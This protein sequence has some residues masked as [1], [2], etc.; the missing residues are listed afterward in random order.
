MIRRLGPVAAL[1]IL[2]AGL[3]GAFAANEKDFYELW[4]KHESD[5][6]RH[7]E[8]IAQC[9]KFSEFNSA[10]PLRDVAKSLEAW[11]LLV[12]GRSNEAWEIFE[13]QAALA[14]DGVRTGTARVAKG[15][16][17]RRER[18]KVAAS[19]KLFYREEIGFPKS[20]AEISN[21]PKIPAEARPPVNDRF[22]APW[23][24]RLSGFEKMPG[25]ENQKYSLECAELGPLSDLR[26]SLELPYAG[27]LK[28]KPVAVNPGPAGSIVSFQGSDSKAM[29]VIGE[30]EAA[31]GIQLAFAGPGL[32]MVCDGTHWK[33]F[34][35]PK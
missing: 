18:E 5:P 24:Y 1:L 29:T 8:I 34:L 26:K 4:K 20:L 25:F 31:K 11:H 13:S 23:K 30:G 27:H 28:I 6:S 22:G 7:D 14:G 15:W 12:A 3:Q 32:V 33:V 35:K 17:S 10:D 9:R 16:L 21:H 19:L 2:L